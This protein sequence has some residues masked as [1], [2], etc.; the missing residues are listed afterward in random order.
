MPK[1]YTMSEQPQTTNWNVLVGFW[2]VDG[3]EFI[4]ETPLT[5]NG[6]ADK[7][8]LR[9]EVEA[10]YPRA[11]EILPLGT[12]VEVRSSNNGYITLSN[13]SVLRNMFQDDEGRDDPVRDVGTVWFDGAPYDV[14]VLFSR[15][16]G[17]ILVMLKP[18]LNGYGVVRF[19]NQINPQQPLS[20]LPRVIREVLGNGARELQLKIREAL[21]AKQ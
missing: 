5:G 10:A 20:E 2:R 21:P 12:R 14:T 7:G 8:K 18:R 15:G 11:K 19:S 3:K 6:I 1:L 13:G 4:N 16:H 9:R 17:C